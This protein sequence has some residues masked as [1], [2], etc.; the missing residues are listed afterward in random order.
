MSNIREWLPFA[1]SGPSLLAP[2]GNNQQWRWIRID[3]RYR[4]A[5]ALKP[6]GR[7]ATFVA[8]ITL[9]RA[10]PA[11]GANIASGVGAGL[12]SK[13]TE[14]FIISDVSFGFRS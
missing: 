10:V 13:S 9:P 6:R 7:I 11:A 14:L 5:A 8:A 3:N 12:Q 1:L 4:S 2:Q